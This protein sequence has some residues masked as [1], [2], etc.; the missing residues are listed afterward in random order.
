MHPATRCR[1]GNWHMCR[2]DL[3]RR[4]TTMNDKS[5]RASAPSSVDFRVL[6]CWDEPRPPRREALPQAQLCWALLV[7]SRLLQNW[8]PLLSLLTLNAK[9]QPFFCLR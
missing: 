2:S 5:P 1:A 9:H 4:P 6:P 8:P 3:R 7:L